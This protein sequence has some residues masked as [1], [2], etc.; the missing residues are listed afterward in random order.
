MKVFIFDAEKC[1]GCYNCQVAC[2][3]EHVGNAWPPYSA[4]EPNTGQFW[5]RVDQKEHGQIPMVKVEYTAIPCMHCE[6]CVASA[7]CPSE[8]FVRRD[9]GLIYINSE[10][11]TG[12]MACVEA[13]PYN[14]VFANAELGIAQKCTGCAHLVDQGELPHCVD[15]CAT[16]GLRFGDEEDFAD[17]IA[18]AEVLLEDLDT[19]PH[20]YYINMPHL[21][22][23]GEVWD[24]ETDEIIEH[25]KITLIENEGDSDKE[26]VL[27][28]DDFGDFKFEKLRA[29]K[30]NLTIEADG[31]EPI[32]RNNI[33]LKES[34]YLGDF[35]LTRA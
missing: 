29:G 21:F 5:I 7:A 18:N 16:G 14:A 32:Q 15:F 9:D 31:Y 12:C 22:L 24:P 33:E 27:E 26:L 23:G 19:K 30:Y 8:A 4:P 34:T 20:V 25:A 2:K 3:D 28:S 13:C 17:E 10:A 35:P 1:N 11:C 6:N